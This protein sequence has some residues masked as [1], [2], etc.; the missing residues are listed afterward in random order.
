V[1]HRA[2]VARER[3]DGQYDLYRSEW[4]AHQWQLQ[5]LLDL[6]SHEG[7]NGIPDCVDLTPTVRG[8][9]FATIVDEC[10]DFQ[11]DEA[12]YRVCADGESQPFFVAWFGFPGAGETHVDAGGVVAVDASD[13]MTD[14]ALVR[15]WLAG[16][17]GVLD[18]LVENGDLPA[19]EARELLA[20]RLASWASDREHYVRGSGENQ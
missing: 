14:G 8:V 10:L 18:S 3:D 6:Y 20:S 19:A 5:R 13:P 2:L 11:L 12:L 9:P 15:G 1:A 4:S 17:K 16:A 7:T